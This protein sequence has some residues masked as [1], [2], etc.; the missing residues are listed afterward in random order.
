MLFVAENALEKALVEAVKNPSSASDFYRL[1][2]ESDLLVMGSAEGQEDAQEKF[3][4]AP[5]SNL[6]LVTGLKDGSQYLPVFSSLARMQEFVKQE[7]KF[8]SINGRDLLD[9]TRGAPVTLNP[10][11]QYGRELSPQQVQQLLGGSRSEERSVV[12]EADYPMPLVQALLPV[13]AARPDIQTAWMIQVTFADRAQQPHPLVGIELDS[14]GGGDWPSLMQAIQAAAEA[15]V[16]GMVFDIQ[17]VDRR[18][19]AGMTGA[20]IQAAPFYVRGA[21]TLN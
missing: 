9:M 21:S 4:L 17:R 20:L 3:S 8:L 16:P 2:L 14:K 5:G 6:R 12:G 7:T 11:S 10:A 1:L 13:F 19:P 15:Q 18:N